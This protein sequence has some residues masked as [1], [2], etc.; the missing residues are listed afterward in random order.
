LILDPSIG[1]RFSSFARFAV[2]ESFAAQKR[3]TR[4]DIPSFIR[5]MKSKTI[6][7]SVAVW[8]AAG[9]L[10]FGSS[11]DG[12]WKLNH[13]KSPAARGMGHNET[14]K[15]EPMFPFKTKVTI[16]G[17]NAKGKPSHD[18]WTGMFDGKDYP[19]T[20]DPESDMR[21]YSKVDDHTL[22]FWIKKGGKVTA[23]GKIVVAPDGKSRTVTA[24]GRNAKGKMVRT[25]TVYDKA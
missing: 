3:L 13:K 20:G 19:V 16:D 11:F 18:E 10:C 14:V 5:A 21:S 7:A 1:L 17:T 12:T 9:A 25:T 15:Y 22:N 23:S 24:M 8:L 4:R 6:L 2:S